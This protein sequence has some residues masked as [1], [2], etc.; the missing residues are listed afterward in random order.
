[1]R[2]LAPTP[3]IGE[4]ASAE[5]TARGGSVA[6]PLSPKPTV[7]NH[8]IKIYFLSLKPHSTFNN[9]NFHLSNAQA[10]W[11]T[12]ADLRMRNAKCGLEI[13]F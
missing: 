11:L 7:K 9:L 12:I 2:N 8:S 1:M 4:G 5:L 13:Q 10:A 3:A 6:I